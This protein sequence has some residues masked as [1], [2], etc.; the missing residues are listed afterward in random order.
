[1]NKVD[2]SR[3]EVLFSSS[4]TVITKATRNSDNKALLIKKPANAFPSL[5]VVE[6]FKKDFHTTQ[7]LHQK[8]PKHFI[9]MIEMVEQEN[10]SVFLVE[11]QDGDSLSNYLKNNTLGTEEF[12][13]LA[14]SMTKALNECHSS[15]ILHRDIKLA[16]FILGREEEVKLIDFVAYKEWIYDFKKKIDVELV[17]IGGVKGIEKIKQCNDK[18][19]AA[20]SILLTES[21]DTIFVSGKTNPLMPVTVSLISLYLHLTEGLTENAP[22]SFGI[23]GWMICSFFQD[24]MGYQLTN[25]AEKLLEKTKNPNFNE[26]LVRFTIGINQIFGGTFKQ[27][28]YHFSTGSNYAIA[29]GEYVFG[30]YNM[31]NWGMRAVTNGENFFNVIS[32][33]EVYQS[34]CKKI[35]NIFVR[36]LLECDLHFAQDLAGIR[37]FN[38]KY[39]LEG[40]KEANWAGSFFIFM[41]AMVAYHNGEIEKAKGLLDEREPRL[42][43][44]IGHCGYYASQC[45]HALCCAHFYKKT[46][47]QIHL[48]KFESFVELFKSYNVISP[49]YYGPMYQLLCAVSESFKQNAD[50]LSVLN[51]FNKSSESAQKYGLPIVSAVINELMLDYCIEKNFLPAICQY[52][53]EK[54]ISIWESMAAASKEKNSKLLLQSTKKEILKKWI[55][56]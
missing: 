9:N 41:E 45:Y 34:F 44:T 48:T 36:D 28:L 23:S 47:E 10:G 50:T 24:P 55:K 16:N 30:C 29:H 22:V 56:I 20:F 38:P 32:K 26:A 54:L 52:Y 6:S 33:L 25:L 15:Q 27:G 53:F 17:Q 19:M 12:L 14:I 7:T 35:G 51:L 2:Y 3:T 11:E 46:G 49:F 4:N 13:K 37:K 1:M 8:F 39:L 21:L 31:N 18:E 40:I 5:R 42:V 43:E